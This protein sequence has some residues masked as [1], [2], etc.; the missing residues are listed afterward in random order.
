MAKG[1]DPAVLFYTSDF[2]TGTALMTYTQRGKYITLLCLQH[3]NG[4]LSEKDMKKIC[5][6]ADED[7]FSKFRQDE[8]GLY[9]NE[10]LEK[11]TAKRIR[12][13]ERQSEIAKKRWDGAKG[14]AMAFPRECL[15]E[16]EN[17]NKDINKKRDEKGES[18]GGREER[19][20]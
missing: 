14:D 2:L 8:E 19:R 4:R 1:K 17:E 15:L 18:E 11:E 7:I 3:Q 9:Y 20:Q 13:S 12:F 10:R 6:K 16:N 5:G